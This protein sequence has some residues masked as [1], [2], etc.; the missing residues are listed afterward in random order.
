M[1]AWL[2]AMPKYIHPYYDE[3]AR[4]TLCPWEVVRVVIGPPQDNMPSN[5]IT[6]VL[7]ITDPNL[8]P[9]ITEWANQRGLPIVYSKVVE[10]EK[11][12]E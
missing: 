4:L 7:Y 9:S 2:R 5:T 11:D 8:I 6:G 1:E 10:G 3:Y 12:E